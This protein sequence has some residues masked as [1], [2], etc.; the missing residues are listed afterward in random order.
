VAAVVFIRELALRT[1]SGEQ[2]LQLE[3][4]DAEG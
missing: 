4:V 3:F 1:T 2:R